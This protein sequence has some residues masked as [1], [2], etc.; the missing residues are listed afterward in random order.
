MRKVQ[1]R[2]DQITEKKLQNEYKIFESNEKQ[3][4]WRYLMGSTWLE[5]TKM[6]VSQAKN[7][8]VSAKILISSKYALSTLLNLNNVYLSLLSSTI[9]NSG[10]LSSVRHTH[11]IKRQQVYNLIVWK[12]YRTSV[13]CCVSTMPVLSPKYK[14]ALRDCSNSPLLFRF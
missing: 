6:S 11:F 10:N 4:E 12:L 14:I 1:V 3:L 13:P 5:A 9:S 8:F 7:L 2:I